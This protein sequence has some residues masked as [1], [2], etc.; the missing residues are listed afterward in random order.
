M[1]VLHV[2]VS[3]P[4]GQARKRELVFELAPGQELRF[5][6]HPEN[7]IAIEDAEKKVSSRHGVIRCTSND[8][9][10]ISDIG[11]LNGTSL[12]GTP[13]AQGA[14]AMLSHGDVATLGDFELRVQ[15][16]TSTPSGG[17]LQPGADRLTRAPE[18]PEGAAA[19]GAAAGGSGAVSELDRR[20]AQAAASLEQIYERQLDAPGAARAELLQNAI[21]S[22]TA[23]LPATEAV[24]LLRQLANHYADLPADA[25]PAAPAAPARPARAQSAGG[26][27]ATLGALQEFASKYVPDRPLATGNDVERFLE[28]LSGL[29]ESLLRWLARG[30]QS[31]AVFADEF[32]AEVTLMFQRSN[33]PLKA[34]SEPE[35]CKYLLDWGAQT[36]VDERK[37]YLD[38]VLKDLA[39]HQ[40]G[41][42]AGVRETVMHVL[43]RV[44]PERV[45]S[46][47]EQD[48]GWSL[49]SK[50][51]KAWTKF[52]QLYQELVEERDKLFD[53]VISP[54]IQQG[55][56]QQHGVDRPADGKSPN[57]DESR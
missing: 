19:A 56:L 45:M 36:S 43:G 7:D 3:R 55:Y 48:G 4:D 28:L 49:G 50:Q 5:G 51:A 53:E 18:G 29:S 11:S 37:H 41:V 30:I 34:M 22:A 13:L 26:A 14:A 42:L 32:G 21:R 20:A 40:L 10:Q 57:P 8:A 47:A 2:I 38:A 12:N 31:R 24:T 33:N 1:V 39:E 25:I 54:A 6:R 44:S 35:L 23:D 17:G 15:L 27:N 16:P 46:L 52:E 9:L